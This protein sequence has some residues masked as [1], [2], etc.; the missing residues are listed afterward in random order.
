[1]SKFLVTGGYGF[2]GSAFIRRALTLGHSICNVDCLTYAASTANLRNFANCSALQNYTV[3]IRQP[4]KMLAI[5]EREKPDAIFH[6]AAETH[7]DR[8]IISS[9]DFITTNILGTSNLLEIVRMQLKA[10]DLGDEFKFIH[11]STDEVFGSLEL[12]SLEQFNE[13]SNYSPNSPY[14]ASKAASDHLARAWYS[15]Y[16]VPTIIT[17]CSNNYGPF[18]NVEKLIPKVI[19]CALSGSKIPIYGNGLNIRDWLHVDD[20]VNALLLIEEHG[21]IG[22]Q[23]LIGGN[24]QQSNIDMVRMICAELNKLVQSSSSYESQIVFVDDRLGHDKRYAI[25]SSKIQKELGWRQEVDL[26]VGIQDTVNWYVNEFK[27]NKL[28]IPL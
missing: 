6:F 10:G 11:V 24:N 20:H 16:G 14:S 2:I 25:D 23:Y 8:S 18:Q 22:E 1:M 26:S 7:V 17:N 13:N 27:S 3:D 12:N 28:S 21:I 5:F 4:E 19:A 15:T 9:Q